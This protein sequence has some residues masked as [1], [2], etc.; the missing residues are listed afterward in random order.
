MDA[1]LREKTIFTSRGSKRWTKIG[2]RD[3]YSDRSDMWG[4]HVISGDRVKMEMNVAT[5]MGVFGFQTTPLII[6][7]FTFL[8]NMMTQSRL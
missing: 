3:G 5:N 6:A 4:K 8:S 2:I 7:T 1:I